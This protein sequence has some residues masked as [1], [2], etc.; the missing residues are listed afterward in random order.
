MRTVRS[1][2]CGRAATAT[3][4]PKR[5]LNPPPQNPPPREGGRDG[6][7][8]KKLGVVKIIS[9]R[10]GPNP[11]IHERYQRGAPAQDGCGP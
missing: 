8:N 11:H 7:R 10:G 2:L 4:A 6:Q 5:V 3:P 1:W 9:R